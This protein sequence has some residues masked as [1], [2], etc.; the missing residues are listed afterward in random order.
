MA[1]TH[2]IYL[3][4]IDQVREVEGIPDDPQSRS[5][6]HDQVDLIKRLFFSLSLGFVLVPGFL[7]FRFAFLSGSSDSGKNVLVYIR[8][9]FTHIYSHFSMFH[10]F[11]KKFFF[12]YRTCA[13]Y[14]FF[15][16]HNNFEIN[17][18]LVRNLELSKTINWENNLCILRDPI[19]FRCDKCRKILWNFCWISVA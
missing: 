7:Y 5:H 4:G 12:D 9:R 19:F 15:I 6:K 18:L 13:F 17:L 8:Y 2:V 1:M 14:L 10:M 3:E 11:V 16:I